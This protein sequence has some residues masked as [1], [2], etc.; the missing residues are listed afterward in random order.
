MTSPAALF[1]RLTRLAVASDFNGAIAVVSPEHTRYIHT[2]GMADFTAGTPFSPDTVTGI[3]SISK[4]FTATALLML[5]DQVQL[6]LSDPLSRYLPAYRYADQMTLRQVLLMR[7]GIPD[8]VNLLVADAAANRDLAHPEDDPAVNR[9]AAQDLPLASIITR[10]N[11]VSL[12]SVPGTV[13]QYSNSDY[14]LLGGVISQVAGQNLA[15]VL[16]EMIWQPLGMT[17][18][19]LGTAAA[20]AESYL[21]IA[22]QPVTVGRGT[23]TLGDGGVVT[24]LTDMVQWA[25]AVMQ[26]KLLPPALWQEAHTLVADTYGYAWIKRGTWFGHGG[27]ILG[28]LADI[29][30]SPRMDTAKIW[31]TNVIPIGPALAE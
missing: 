13:T 7:A 29:A 15:S 16:Q 9:A 6:A 12:T 27:R 31:L 5:A 21:R 17:A 8:Y 10:L 28:Y 11:T 1:D 22:G 3:G 20:E 14:A 4:Q 18:T 24:T 25:Q 2:A 26:G 19:R 30:F 23:H